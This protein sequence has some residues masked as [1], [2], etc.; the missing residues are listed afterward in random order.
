MCQRGKNA[1]IFNRFQE[2]RSHFRKTVN[3]RLAIDA[4]RS[5]LGVRI[6]SGC[7][8]RSYERNIDRVKRL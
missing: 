1:R 2:S 8:R 3:L 6:S 4:C 7:S 5:A